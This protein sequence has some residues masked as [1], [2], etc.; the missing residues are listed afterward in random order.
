[1]AGEW[2]SLEEVKIEKI[3]V[4]VGNV[5]VDLGFKLA[6]TSVEDDGVESE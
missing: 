2:A 5:D 6:E 4:N 1:V 3:V